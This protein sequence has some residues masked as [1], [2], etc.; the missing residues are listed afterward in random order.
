M[1]LAFIFVCISVMIMFQ[2]RTVKFPPE[3]EMKEAVQVMFKLCDSKFPNLGDTE[4]RVACYDQ[5]G[6]KY[7][8]SIKERQGSVPPNWV[9]TRTP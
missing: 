3:E 6:S 8:D 2:P 1:G 4:F 5:L 7:V 9:K